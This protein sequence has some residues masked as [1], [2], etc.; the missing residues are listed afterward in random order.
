MFIALTPQ[1]QL[2][3]PSTPRKQFAGISPER[4]AAMEAEFAELTEAFQNASERHGPCGL[5]LVAAR[6]YLDRIMGNVRVVKYLAHNFPERFAQ[7]QSIL[8]P[9]ERTRVHLSAHEDAGRSP[10]F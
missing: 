4:F 3:D 6:G 7:F 2:V 1:S 8:E 5:A 10:A 9:L